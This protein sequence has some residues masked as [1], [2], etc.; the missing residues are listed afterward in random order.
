MGVSARTRRRRG[1]L[2]GGL[3]GALGGYGATWW[4]S[5]CARPSQSEEVLMRSKTS[6]K[7]ESK[8]S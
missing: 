5:V 3:W 2:R 8:D 4:I 7:V 6:M 1:A